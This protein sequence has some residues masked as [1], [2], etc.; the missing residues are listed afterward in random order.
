[1]TT[2]QNTEECVRDTQTE[3]DKKK[4]AQ[5]IHIPVILAGSSL[6]SDWLEGF[7]AVWLNLNG[8]LSPTAVFCCSLSIPLIC[9]LSLWASSTDLAPTLARL[10]SLL[11]ALTSHV[12]LLSLSSLMLSCSSSNT[13]FSPSLS[14]HSSAC[15]PLSL[16]SPS[17]ALLLLL[18]FH[19]ASCSYTFSSSP[20]TLSS[21]PV[22]C[23]SSH[24]LL[25]CRVRKT[26]G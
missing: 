3:P 1:M 16:H 7:N 19:N 23:L 5:H 6:A 14:P 24:S 4:R 9:T 8:V 18:W 26:Y 22:S 10:P 20:R 15:C 21:L 13:P 17:L 11:M 25:S 12:L 2:W